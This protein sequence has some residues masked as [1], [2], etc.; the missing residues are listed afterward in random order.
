ELECQ[1]LNARIA[2][3]ET[4][5]L[6]PLIVQR[7]L[8]GERL[9]PP[10]EA[11]FQWLR[12]R[13]AMTDELVEQRVRLLLANGPASFARTVARRL[14]AAKAEPLLRWAALIEQPQRS[15]DELIAAPRTPVEDRALADGWRRLAR[16]NPEA[17]LERFRALERSRDLDS[18]TT[19]QLA[20][21]L[22]LGL[23]W[24]RRGQ[25]ALETFRDVRDGDFDDAARGWQARAAL[26]TGEW[27]TA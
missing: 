6:E 26:W 17:A 19:S 11:P 21:S 10:C 20:L 13:G 15:I 7:W 18:R 24:D 16:S 22:A 14:P 25:A 5:G 12:D 3:A 23:A 4:D 8:T 2:L 9:P 27:R 1:W